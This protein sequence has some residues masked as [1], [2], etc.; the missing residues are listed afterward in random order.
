MALR[1]KEKQTQ[2]KTRLLIKIERK[3]NFAVPLPLAGQS[4]FRKRKEI[5]RSQEYAANLA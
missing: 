2:Y 1:F 3:E 4:T 5:A